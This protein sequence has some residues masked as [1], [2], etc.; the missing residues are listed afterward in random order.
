MSCCFRTTCVFFPS[1]NFN[2]GPKDTADGDEINR[3]A[4]FEAESVRKDGVISQLRDNLEQ[5][6]MEL[7]QGKKIAVGDSKVQLRVME[8]EKDSQLKQLEIQALKEQVRVTS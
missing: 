8:L 7:Q 2:P 4:V 3:L 1:T 5:L 6:N